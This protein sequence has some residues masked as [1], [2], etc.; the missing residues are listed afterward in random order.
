M[1]NKYFNLID[2]GSSKIRFSIYDVNLKIKFSEAK[3]VIID[4]NF[5][6]HFEVIKN[7]IRKA[8]KK[9]QITSKT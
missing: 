8:E 2:F 7:I 5:V 6:N 4:N 3:S 9:F 1:K